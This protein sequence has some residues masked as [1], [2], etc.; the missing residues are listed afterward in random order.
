MATPALDC[1]RENFRQAHIVAIARRNVQKILEGG[2]WFDDFLTGDDRHW[3][4]F[5]VLVREIRQLN[6]DLTIIMPNSIR[7]TLPLWLAGAKRRIG[8]RRGGRGLLLS[9]GPEPKRQNGLFLPLPMEDYYLGLCQWL[10]LPLPAVHKPRLYIPAEVQQRGDALLSRYGITPADRLIGL[11]PGASFGSSKCWP[12]EHFAQ[13]AELLQQQL[14]A[15]IILFAGPAEHDIARSI[16]SLSKAQIID[17]SP[18]NVDL[19]L[20]KPLIKRCDVLVT[21]DTGPRHYAVAF[22]VP[23]V[24]VMGPTDPRWT[25]SNLEYTIVL[26]QDLPC[27]PCHQK[28]CPTDHACMKNITPQGVLDA[29]RT[30][31]ERRR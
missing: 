15:K 6:P 25:A 4:S 26:R 5:W 20:L 17:T 14:N 24:V 3:H 12:V 19:A 21:N 11:N 22:D 18:D 23:V 2:P 27:A 28:T 29:V 8:Y 7:S 31:W 13:T 30:F 1:L 9:G 16:V 10:D